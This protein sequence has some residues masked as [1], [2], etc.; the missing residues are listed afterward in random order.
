MSGFCLSSIGYEEL[1]SLLKLWVLLRFF[2]GYMDTN[3]DL[4]LVIR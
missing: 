3:K 4:V 1:S 2:G